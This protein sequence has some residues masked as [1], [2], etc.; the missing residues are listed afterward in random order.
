MSFDSKILTKFI[1]VSSYK[2]SD[3][4]KKNA[5]HETANGAIRLSYIVYSTILHYQLLFIIYLH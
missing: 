5:I 2:F 4:R 1:D 3:G